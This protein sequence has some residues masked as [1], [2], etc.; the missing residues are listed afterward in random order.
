MCEISGVNL[1]VLDV[2]LV[3]DVEV[4]DVVPGPAVVVDEDVPGPPVVV[5]GGGGGL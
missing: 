3:L 4:E 1:D 5:T 2:E